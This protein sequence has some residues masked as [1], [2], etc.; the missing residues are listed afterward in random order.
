LEIRGGGGEAAKRHRAVA[1]LSWAAVVAV[2]VAFSWLLGSAASRGQGVYPFLAALL[3]LA[4][5]LL[6]HARGRRVA[7]YGFLFFQLLA[8]T[9]VLMLE[10]VLHLWPG[11]LGGQVANVA[12]TGY[13]WQRGGIYMLDPHRG[14]VLRPSFGRRMY[15]SGH[16]WWHQTNEDAYRGPRLERADVILLGDSM[17][18]GHGVEEPDT[19]A[20]RFAAR[21]GLAAANLGQ[22]GTCLLQSFLALR[23][24]GPRLR[25]RVVYACAHFS[26]LDEVVRYYERAELRRFLASPSGAPAAPLAREEYRPQLDWNLRQLFAR[27][28]ALPLRVGGISGAVVR[29]LR[30]RTPA[31]SAGRRDPFMPTREEIAAPLEALAAD[32]PP[33]ERLPWLTERRAA[34]EIKLLSDALGARLV[35]F[36]LGYPEAHSRAVEALAEELG[37][38]YCP[39]GRVAL[40]RSLAGEVVYLSDDGHWNGA[41]AEIVAEELAGA[42]VSPPR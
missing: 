4:V 27:N 29:S 15:W 35:L 21:T 18:Y 17:V 12:Y 22:Q 3:A 14:P 5:A 7:L 37:C 42:L 13:H 11:V 33:E 25:P 36:D 32:A 9:G 41:G 6:A 23:V 1:G 24:H 26:D 19:I 38:G 28:L 31:S 2:S 20:A 16:W 30:V 40:A 10:A 8:S 34:A 39:A